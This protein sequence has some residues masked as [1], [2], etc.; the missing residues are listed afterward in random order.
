MTFAIAL[1]VPV[2]TMLA[3][4]PAAIAGGENVAEQIA[5]APLNPPAP[6]LNG[7]R[8]SG[9]YQGRTMFGPGDALLINA[10]GRHGLQKGQRYFVRRYVADRFTPAS[11]D[12][13]PVSIHTAGW[14]TIVDTRDDDAVAQVTHACD[15]ILEGDYLEPYTDPVVPEPAPG[16]TADYD[17]PARIVMG[18]Q[19]MQTG[20]AGTLMLINRG[21][22]HGVRAGQT[23]TIFRA[24]LK[25]H[26]PLADVGEATILSVRP[27][28][29]LM[30]IDSSRDAVYVGDLA[31]IRR[32]P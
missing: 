1:V 10:G 30:R 23:L 15:G 16:G 21:S 20:A 13:T 19:R 18:D 32:L 6:P 7:M 9:G 24:T 31:A 17:H 22:D 14:V 26:G 4:Q 12:F 29:S 25:G 8:V 2:V 3:Q 11:L 28:T 5:C 27:Q